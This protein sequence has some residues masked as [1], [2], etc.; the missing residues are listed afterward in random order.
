MEFERI[1]SA[2]KSYLKHRPIMREDHTSGK[3]IDRAHVELW[4]A[5][6]AS[7][8]EL[9]E[10]L[11]DVVLEVINL[12]IFAG[13]ENFPDVVMGKIIKNRE[14]FPKELFQEGD[15]QTIYEARKKDLDKPQT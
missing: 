6:A 4:E 8:E 7:W 11:A 15:F 12:V 1:I 2:Q 9:P 3:L 14:R 13:I 10:E 5:H